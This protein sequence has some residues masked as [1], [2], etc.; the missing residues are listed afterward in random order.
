MREAAI[1]LGATFLGGFFVRPSITH[2]P[3]RSDAT[4]SI[5]RRFFESAGKDGIR[6]WFVNVEDAIDN[7]TR[8]Y[9]HVLENARLLQ[10]K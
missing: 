8:D 7:I 2:I 1:K 6:R 3:E 4:G 5:S 9:N 10:A